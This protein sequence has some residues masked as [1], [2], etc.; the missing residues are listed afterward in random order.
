[1]PT[2][3]YYAISGNPLFL[4][5]ASYTAIDDRRF[6]QDAL[7]PGIK[8]T[9]DFLV[10]LASGMQITIATGVAYV[11]GAN[12]AEQGMYR[13]YKSTVGSNI[14][15]N[16]ADG[17]NPRIDQVI[18]RVMDTDS[19]SSTYREARIECVPGTAAAGATLDNRT[20]AANLATLTESSKS[21]LRLAD[22]L[23]PAGAG[24]IIAGNIRDR[25]IQCGRAGN[26][27][28][29]GTA[30]STVSVTSTNSASP[31]DI[32]S[33]PFDEYDGNP[34]MFHFFGEAI[35]TSGPIFWIG[36]YE[37]LV[38]G[39]GYTQVATIGATASAQRTPASCYF[40]YTPPAGYRAYKISGYM[41][42][43]GTGTVYAGSGTGGGVAPALLEVI[44]Q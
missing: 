42:S 29:K 16:A 10:S 20:G 5:T 27:L 43:A 28:Y 12:V 31:T 35:S 7:Y 26:T 4:Q 38:S 18:I 22:I 17:T 30:T 37:A 15:V 34:M 23:V 33:I 32:V 1:M 41:N 2:Y 19:D 44:R 11:L 14:T 8:S 40:N 6:F 36:L 39:G 3:P 25:R 24:S 9:G 13:V 21:V